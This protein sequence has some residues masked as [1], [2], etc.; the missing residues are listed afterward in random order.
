MKNGISKLLLIIA[1]LVRSSEVPAQ[2]TVEGSFVHGG[3]NRSYAV[4][5]PASYIPGQ[6]VPLLF[7]LHGY[8]KDKEYQE[9]N[10][11]FRPVADTARFLVV[12]PDGTKERLTK[13]RFWNFGSVMGSTVDDQGFLEALIDTLAKRFSIDQQ[14]VYCTGMSN[15]TFMAY[16]LGCKSKRFAAVGGVA[17]GMSVSMYKDCEPVNPIPIIHIHGTKDP[18]NKYKGSSSAIGIEAILQFWRDKNHCSTKPEVTAI[19][20]AT[21][22]DKCTAERIVYSGGIN[23][24]RVELIKITGGGHTWPGSDKQG[25][26]L[27]K[28]CQDFDARLEIWRF[29]REFKLTGN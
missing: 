9:S 4:Y 23:G 12:H 19:E 1:Y 11:D 29:F 18:I 7:N 21:P 17:G 26:L 25:G 8:G 3:I 28:V 16:Y 24:H 27:G 10:R 6:P 20:D 22:L 2:Q 15:G 14:R 13:Q 5:V